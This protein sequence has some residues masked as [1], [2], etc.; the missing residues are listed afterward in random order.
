MTNPNSRNKKQTEKNHGK[1]SKLGPEMQKDQEKI[2]KMLK[3]T[4]K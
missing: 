3:N 2:A 4:N 1:K